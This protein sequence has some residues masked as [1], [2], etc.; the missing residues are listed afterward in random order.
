[1]PHEAVS[2]LSMDL[3]KVKTEAFLFKGGLWI[4]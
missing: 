2:L 1:M 4:K 3:Y